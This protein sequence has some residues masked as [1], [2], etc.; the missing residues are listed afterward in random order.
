MGEAGESVAWGAEE[1][2]SPEEDAEENDT[3]D[4]QIKMNWQ[5]G[6]LQCDSPCFCAITGNHHHSFSK[7]FTS[8]VSYVC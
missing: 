5:H 3:K 8:A 1:Q 4:L 2:H 6:G 7:Y